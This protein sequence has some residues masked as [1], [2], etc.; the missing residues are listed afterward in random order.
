MYLARFTF[1]YTHT[2][3]TATPS[4]FETPASATPQVRSK[5]GG[6]PGSTEAQDT[7]T[8]LPDAKKQKPEDGRGL[9][10]FLS[11]YHSEDD[12]SFSELM[13]KAKE[14]HM[15]KHAWLY[16][17]EHEA[18][19]ALE[20]PQEKLA[21]TDGSEA[22]GGLKA[23][24]YR[25]ASVKTWNYTAKNSLMYIP[26][27]VDESTK[28]KVENPAKGR[29]VVHTNTRLSS[30]FLKKTQAALA[31][32]AGGDIGGVGVAKDK[33]GIDGKIL[34]PAESPQ[35]NGYGFVATPQIQPGMFMFE[36][37]LHV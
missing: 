30:A 9:D 2:P 22:G 27:G 13:V 35:V 23:I 20:G 10:D 6:A 31:K 24:E 7:D 26:E 14:E 16:E 29:E 25:P 4:T 32:A 36:F 11:K 17:R 33:V 3:A 34:G 18:V 8:D 12:A 5:R 37:S 19:A 15:R 21:I 1:S 28:E